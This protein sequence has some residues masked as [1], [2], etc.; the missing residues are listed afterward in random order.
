MY[1][2]I[3]YVLGVV[4]VIDASRYVQKLILRVKLW[5][6]KRKKKKIENACRLI[7]ADSLD[8]R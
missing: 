1:F 6:I 2:S 3:V 5:G 4:S 8:W 7:D